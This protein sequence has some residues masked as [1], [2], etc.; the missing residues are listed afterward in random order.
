[1]KRAATWITLAAFAGTSTFAAGTTAW[2]HSLTAYFLGASMDGEV[3]VRGIPVTVDVPF[4]DIW[5]NLEF[6]AMFNYRAEKDRLSLN[7][8]LIYMGLG[9]SSPN[10]L[11]EI[12]FDQWMVEG[13]AG[14]RLGE[15]IEVIGGLRYNDLDA[16]LQTRGPGGLTASQGKSWVDPFVGA[17]AIVPLS[18]SFSLIARGDVGG[19]GVGSEMAWQVAAYLRYATSN[20]VSIILGYR[21]LDMEYEDGEGAN[22][23]VYDMTIQG[24]AFGVTWR[25]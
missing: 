23:F 11:A 24:P 14:W 15:A 7:A 3:E 16:K 10:G 5:S 18:G 12:D 21:C 19:F 1:M 4:S 6:G 2:T 25:F 22:R 8:D 9:G 13:S 20:S 17:R